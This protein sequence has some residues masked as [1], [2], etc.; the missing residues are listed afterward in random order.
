MRANLILALVLI[1]FC[2]TRG[3][4]LREG[5]H[6]KSQTSQFRAYGYGGPASLGPFRID[7]KIAGTP[8]NQLLAALGRRKVPN[9]DR[10]C[11]EDPSDGTYL[12]VARGSDDSTLA[13]GVALSRFP[14]CFKHRNYTTASISRWSTEKGIR[15]GSAEA[16]VIAAYGKPTECASAKRDPKIFFPGYE[17]PTPEIVA[18]LPQGG[19]VLQYTAKEGA[20]DLSLARFGISNGLVVWIEL[21]HDE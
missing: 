8:L 15:L 9:D 6:R 10:V 16:A 20:P 17:E 12:I 3:G 18:K 21:S 2:G 1:A 14:N 13:R 5:Y 19:I 4:G 7:N 11:F